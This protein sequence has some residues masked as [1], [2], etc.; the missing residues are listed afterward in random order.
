MILTTALLNDKFCNTKNNKFIALT[1]KYHSSVNSKLKRFIDISG[2]LVGLLILG[3]IF[4]P[5][6]IAIKKDDGGSIF[7]SQIRCGHKGK[8]F[9]I[10][11]F[12]SMVSNA[13]ALK[14]QV[15]NDIEGAFFKSKNDPRITKIGHFLRKTCLDEFL[16]K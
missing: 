8:K 15:K 12:R 14:S 3:F 16:K 9:R 2:A 4:L 11:K 5:I 10:W 7:Y 6:A 13:D 1:K